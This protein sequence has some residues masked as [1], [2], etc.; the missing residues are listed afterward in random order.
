M[1]KK[2]MNAFLLA[3]VLAITA[4]E[5]QAKAQNMEHELGWM[6]G[7][8]AYTFN[9][10]TLAEALDKMDSCGIHYVECYSSQR[11]GDG[12]EGTTDFR[13]NASTR[14]KLKALFKKKNKQ[15]VGYGVVSPKDEEEWRQVFDFAK[16]MGIQVITA[17]PKNEHWD[18]I[19]S[20]CDRYQI[21]VAIHDH[22]RPS[23]YW[24]PDS[25]LAA[26]EGRSPLFGACADIGHW[27]RSGLDPV[28]CIKKLQGHVL[29]LHVKDM[30]EKSRQAHDVVWGN[31]VSNIPGVLKELKKQ[32]FRG[33]FS[34][35]YEYHWENSVPEVKESAAFWRSVVNKL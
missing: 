16:E 24:H 20:L 14:E 22:P 35:E 26:V 32:Q 25:V 6:L 28:E 7:A 12:I 9:R 30:H 15:L 8:Q 3:G 13:M 31:G 18:L 10:F 2:L 34:A 17:E 4:G 19:S 11:I 29:S 23:H 33:L 21:K 1:I 5:R 27:V